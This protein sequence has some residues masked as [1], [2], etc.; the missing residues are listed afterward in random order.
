MILKIFVYLI[1]IL[2]LINN[3][4][5]EVTKQLAIVSLKKQPHYWFISSIYY[6][7]VL[8][9]LSNKELNS[10]SPM[11]FSLPLFLLSFLF[12]SF[13]DLCISLKYYWIV[14]PQPQLLWSLYYYYLIDFSFRFRV[15]VLFY[16][17]LDFDF[18]GSLTLMNQP[19]HVLLCSVN[20][21]SAGWGF[22][23]VDLLTQP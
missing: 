12:E 16:F 21:K 5:I 2:I 10:L 19:P 20:Q 6:A 13:E 18:Y 9:F 3:I 8:P 1:I 23:L 15:L 11:S 4:I 22:R 17:Y 7:N 14:F